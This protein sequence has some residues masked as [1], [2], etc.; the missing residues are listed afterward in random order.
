MNRAKAFWIVAVAGTAMWLVPLPARAQDYGNYTIVRAISGSGTLQPANGG[1]NQAL[2]RNLPLMDGDT[3]WTDSDG[4]VDLLMQDGVYLYMDGSTRIEIDRLPAQTAGTAKAL[5]LRLWKGNLLLDVQSWSPAMTSY[6]ITTPSASLSPSRAGLYLLDVENVD[7]TRAICVD[8]A[9]AVASAG[10]T[11]TLNGR[12]M[13]Y[14]EYGYPPLA[15]M[16][17]TTLP[18]GLMRFRDSNAAPRGGTDVSRQYLP[19][20]LSAYASDLDSYG[21]WNYQPTYGY[22]WCPSDVGPDWA[23][24]T[25]GQWAYNSWG[26]TW[27]PYEPWGWAPFHYGRW[28]Y[29]G[30]IGWGWCPMPYFAPAWVSFWWGDAGWLGWC[31][32]DYWGSP[33]WGPGGWYSCPVGNIYNTNINTIIVRHR[34]APPPH[35]IYPRAQGSPGTLRGSGPRGS[36]LTAAGSLNLSPRDAREFRDGR[37]SSRDLRA[38]LTEPVSLNRRAY[39]SIQASDRNT[40]PRENP[41]QRDLP[42]SRL[43]RGGAS[44]RGE[45]SVG[46][47][48][49]LSSSRNFPSQDRGNLSR[50]PRT[51]VEPRPG[52]RDAAVRSWSSPQGQGRNLQSN[53]S[54]QAS[55]QPRQPLP[56]S[57]VRPYSRVP[58]Q[59]GGYR[60][61][62]QPQQRSYNRGGYSGYA[63]ERQAP[64][65]SWGGGEPSAPR[66]IPSRPSLGSGGGGGFR[67][68]GGG[69][70]R[71]GGGGEFRSGGG[72]G[73]RSAPPAPSGGGGGGGHRR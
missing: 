33:L 2:V 6:V 45:P 50:G 60:Q 41:S 34:D 26:M 67:S 59:S 43:G 35:P 73:A 30:G 31:P 4:R 55:R 20:D 23:P 66:Y 12:Q 8:G 1:Q 9:C 36:S 25:D 21:N 18:A 11:V 48:N 58:D 54:P 51:P 49:N 61:P 57:E 62:I 39:P 24:Y 56:Q 16:N 70:F 40:M 72:G 14:A 53:R 42:N 44:G 32:L 19:S 5:R 15:P 27:V 64:Q 63:P 17:S 68:G 3:L 29:S 38:R 46:R 71:S 10:Q 65:R 7:R 22:V 69:G 37:L 52:R 47:G 13:T 28:I